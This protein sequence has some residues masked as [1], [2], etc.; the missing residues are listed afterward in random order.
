MTDYGN[1]FEP[2]RQQPPSD[3]Q[4]GHA[5][6]APQ[7]DPSPYGDM[8]QKNEPSQMAW[9]TLICGI[10]AWTV[11]PIVGGIAAVIIGMG[12]RKK[13]ESGESPDAGETV[14]MIG[15]L[16]GGVQVVLTVLGFLFAGFFFCAIPCLAGLAGA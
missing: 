4:S 5:G 1:D 15:M 6:A 10:A 14:V 7:H 3:D 12:E 9:A 2:P 13:I 11:F 16:L 8:P